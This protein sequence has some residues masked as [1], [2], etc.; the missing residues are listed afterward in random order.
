MERGQSQP[1]L[2]VV[3]K[4]AAALGLEASVLIS[5]VERALP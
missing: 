4:V 3:F 2:Y 1:T 5:L